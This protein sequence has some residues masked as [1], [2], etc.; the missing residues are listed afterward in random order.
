[1][2]RWSTLGVAAVLGVC[3][4]TTAS[5]Q[6]AAARRPVWPDEG[7]YKW[8]P[9]PTVRDIT[10]N[11]L[12]TRLYQFAD[13][14]MLGRRIG[15]VGNFKGTAYIAR[16]FKRLGLTPAGDNGDYFQNLPYG[17]LKVDSTAARLIAA[18]GPLG[19]KTDWVP[20]TP[21]TANGLSAKADV[22]DVSTVFAGRWGDTTT[23]D[24]AVFGGRIAVFAATPAA[25]GRA[26]RRLCFAATR[27]P[28][29]SVP[30]RRRESK[31]VKGPI[32]SREARE[33]DGVERPL[34]VIHE[35]SRLAPLES[36]SSHS[37]LHR[38]PP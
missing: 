8:A 1:V 19:R 24:P 3:V 11:D 15:D 27:C 33:A 29:S 35:R 23:L 10:A 5:A 7:P 12:R 16:E 25:A 32:L 22:T 36:C 17:P 20:V 30:T 18:G 2:S 4:S 14:S 21:T 26:P 37:T 9:R 38:S 6:H 28:T 13:D 34:V 31:R